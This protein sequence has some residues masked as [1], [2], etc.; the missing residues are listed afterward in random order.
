MS[1]V[2]PLVCVSCPGFP[3]DCD[4]TWT[5]HRV[6]LS[7]LI[8]SLRNFV[9]DT[10]KCATA[11]RTIPDFDYGHVYSMYEPGDADPV[12]VSDL[13]SLIV[14]MCAAQD[15]IKANASQARARVSE[16]AARTEAAATDELS[17]DQALARAA[18]LT[19][20]INAIESAKTVAL[21]GA[22][23]S[24]DAVLEKLLEEFS[25]V[26]AALEEDYDDE[27]ALI[28][29][30]TS[31]IPRIA[32]ALA[33]SASLPRPSSLTD[34]TL[35]VLEAPLPALGLIISRGNAAA[36]LRVVGLAKSM[37]RVKLGGNLSF[38]VRLVEE[39]Y[40]RIESSRE[41][42][43]MTLANSL[44]VD[45]IIATMPSP[46]APSSRAESPSVWACKVC[47]LANDS[48]RRSCAACGTEKPS[49]PRAGP[50]VS[51]TGLH[52]EQ[53]RFVEVID[54]IC[55]CRASVLPSPS[56]WGVDVTI[57]LSQEIS[58]TSTAST[59]GVSTRFDPVLD[60]FLVIRG[61]SVAEECIPS[62]AFPVCALSTGLDA[63]FCC[64]E[65]AGAGWQQP[66]VSASGVLLV[67]HTMWM[68]SDQNIHDTFYLQ[69]RA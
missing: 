31:W 21:E 11:W 19:E 32:A 2:D 57:T 7:S 64:M 51:V 44:V 3:R 35:R 34:T 10:L 1:C 46:L 50:A 5:C 17:K 20:E 61:V 54:G 40:I 37:R 24:A 58:S 52:S 36:D 68:F 48:T 18:I 29:C 66:A 23:V 45:A 16:F 59:S 38:G 12:A 28:T 15:D 27:G 53:P 62:S 67:A 8:S 6:P 55:V 56:D 26:R 47:S 69:V 65:V 49:L 33:L 13:R 43:N 9:S 4:T 25:S 22:V 39:A 42:F 60:P 63:P 14:E 30:T 41:E